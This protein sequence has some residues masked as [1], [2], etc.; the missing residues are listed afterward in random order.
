MF[1]RYSNQ[2]IE[3]KEPLDSIGLEDKFN[4][5]IEGK[6]WSKISNALFYFK[7]IEVNNNQFNFVKELVNTHLETSCFSI[8][9]TNK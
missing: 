2:Y 6:L 1:I 3:I 7:D 4:L 5:T 9:L 8:V